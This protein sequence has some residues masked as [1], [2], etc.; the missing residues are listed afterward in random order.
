MRYFAQWQFVVM[1]G[2]VAITALGV[3]LPGSDGRAQTP[4]DAPASGAAIAPS[5]PTG[6]QH[7]DFVGAADA[8]ETIE[9]RSPMSGL[10]AKIVFREGQ[11]VRKGDLLFE[12]D[13]RPHRAALDLAMA[14]LRRAQAELTGAEAALVRQKQLGKSDAASQA[15][16]E[17]TVA[18]ADVAKAALDVAKTKVQAAQLGLEST[19]IRSFITGRVGRVHLSAGNSV[20]PGT[21]LTTIVSQDPIYVYFDLDEKHYRQFS[22]QWRQAETAAPAKVPQIPV[23]IGLSTEQDFPHDG[24]IDFVDNHFD[25]KTGT[26]RVRAVLSNADRAMLPGMYARVRLPMTASQKP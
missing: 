13:P 21:A 26:I 1:A 14:E 16:I 7:A 9:V 24:V 23:K 6:D 19:Q 20:L 5:A 11:E 4:P 18:Q 8:V 3:I 2:A 10:L 15:E 17:K 25:P 12:F 22:R